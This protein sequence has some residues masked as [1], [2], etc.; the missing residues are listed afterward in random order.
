MNQRVTARPVDNPQKYFT[1]QHPEMFHSD[2]RG[3]YDTALARRREVWQCWAHDLNV[4]YGPDP[5][6]VMNIY[7]PDR[8][9]SA[10]VV[11]YFHGGRFREGHPAFYDHF[12]QPWVQ[13]GAVFI[14]S[15]YRMEPTHGIADSIDD[16]A[17]AL[18]WVNANATRYGGNPTR[19]TVAGHSA[20]GH[21]AAMVTMTDWSTEQTPV[22][23]ALCMSAIV[24]LRALMPGDPEAA[25]LSPA[26]RI[27][28]APP[29]VLVS[30][31]DPEPHL[32]GQESH[33]H[34]EQGRLLGD[35]L[36]A[37]GLP[38]TTVA[39]PHTDHLATATAFADPD[40]PLFA[41]ARAVVFASPS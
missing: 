3:F 40:S 38:A 36:A 28:H 10:P 24:D 26:L 29:G 35:A 15:G 6:H 34:T 41:A 22:I 23:G 7:S 8:G 14:S 18:A 27:T 5:S 11:L 33:A 31:G 32:K 9:G 19:I 1:C 16:A 21:L 37:T 12:A 25:D 39:L 17:R 2:W 13:A 30:Y 4:L 20:G